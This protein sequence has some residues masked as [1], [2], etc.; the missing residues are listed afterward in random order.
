MSEK[1]KD[2]WFACLPVMVFFAYW[3]YACLFC[4]V[5]TGEARLLGLGLVTLPLL[6]AMAATVVRVLRGNRPE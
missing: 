4:A 2:R 3:L 6:A 5:M 1:T